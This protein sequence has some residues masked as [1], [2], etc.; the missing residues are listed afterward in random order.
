MQG[1]NNS[2]PRFDGKRAQTFRQG[3]W[4][5]K[6]SQSDPP[7]VMDLEFVRSSDNNTWGLGISEEGLIFGSTAN[8]N[9]SMFVPIPNRYFERVRGWAPSTLH[10]I[11]DNH[12]FEPITDKVRQVDQFGGY[13]A[14]AGHSLYTARTFPADW[15]NK[16]A[17]VCGPTGHLVGTF[18][19]RRDG[20]NYTST[21]PTNLLASDDEWSAP[22]M[23]EVG[24]DGAVWVIDWYNYIVQ[25]NPTPHGF[26]TGKGAAYESD[27]RDKK[28]GRIYRIVPVSEQG[29]TLHR[30]SNLAAA[31]NA[32]LVSA[33]RHPSFMWRLHAQRLLV[34]RKAQDVFAP[35]VAM[36]SD[37]SVD[38]IGINAGAIH[39][40]QTLK[41][42]GYLRLDEKLLAAAQVR[43]CLANALRHPSP[44]VRRNALAVLPTDS[45]GLEM[46]LDHAA[47]FADDDMQVRLQAMLTLADMPSSNDAGKL[48]ADVASKTN[49]NTLVDALTS[50]AAVHALPFLNSLTSQVSG[51]SKSASQRIARRVAEH[52]ARGRPD[53]EQLRTLLSALGEMAPAIANEVIEGLTQGLPRDIA[54]RNNDE[55][56]AAFVELF[57]SMEGPIRVKVLRLASQCGNI[58]LEDDA[59]EIIDGLKG[60][61]ADGKA[62]SADR[63]AAARDLVG[64]RAN[65]EGVVAEIVEQIGAQ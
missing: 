58:A 33:L 34:E 26:E 38:A 4:R 1:Y 5:F 54:I 47:L 28:R 12:E 64:F 52:I 60:V 35:L 24:P 55:L 30:F 7:K 6:L 59:S 23:A 45:L 22:I 32:E 41:G 37:T 61:L 49:D 29:D 17:F 31:T 39:A 21:S 42:L 15:W 2:T 62:P 50:A 51:D 14:G 9:P 11:A 10:T 8:R 27:L 43:G 44:G 40:L 19:L 53:A 56:D 48:I 20:A 18:V 63:I 13:T 36:I 3:F 46:L 16:T 57:K 65:D 25:H